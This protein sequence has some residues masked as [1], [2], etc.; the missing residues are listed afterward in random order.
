MPRGTW[1]PP[2]C[3]GCSS[4]PPLES[5]RCR[6]PLFLVAGEGG[7]LRD[8]GTRLRARAEGAEA[9]AERQQVRGRRGTA[10]AEAERDAMSTTVALRMQAADAA[11]AEA[12][13]AEV[14]L[15][16]ERVSLTRFTAE[17]LVRLTAQKESLEAQLAEA[18][19]VA[20]ALQDMLEQQQQLAEEYREQARRSLLQYKQTQYQP[21]YQPRIGADGGD[22][23]GGEGGDIIAQLQ[24]VR[25][26][27]E[28]D[29]RMLAAA[30]LVVS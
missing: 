6:G 26:R 18:S 16:T 15:E 11:L 19:G 27:E 7:R 3:P 10:Q 24:A 23:G 12:A 28:Q 8:E 25:A 4:E 30:A 14:R 21:Q 22:G 1:P 29:R 13:A 17:Q 9:E 2:H 5:R 20:L